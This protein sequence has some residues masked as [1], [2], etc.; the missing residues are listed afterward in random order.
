MDRQVERE[1][2]L[3]EDP[4]ADGQRLVEV[5]PGLVQLADHD[6]A[7]HA[8]GR[9]LLPEQ[10]GRAVDAVDGG[11]HEQRRVGRPETGPQLT[12]EVGIARE[13]RAG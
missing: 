7:R 10:P 9:A 8:D 13:R 4:L 5:G 6:G 1:D 11:D 3:T 12:H 2:T